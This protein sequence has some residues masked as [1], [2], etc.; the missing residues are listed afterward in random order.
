[1]HEKYVNNC[2]IFCTEEFNF[3]KRPDTL[4]KLSELMFNIIKNNGGMKERHIFLV[5]ERCFFFRKAFIRIINFVPCYILK[6]S[7][8]ISI[9]IIRFC[10]YSS[11]Y[12][13][14]LPR[15]CQAQL[16][17]PIKNLWE[18]THNLFCIIAILFISFKTLKNY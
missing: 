14:N 2:V 13:K 3:R 4:K 17:I 5:F 6:F 1:M 11:S 12:R 18:Y 8:Y 16:N 15:P 9:Y 10:D 7:Q